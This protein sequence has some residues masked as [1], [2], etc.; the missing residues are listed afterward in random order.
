MYQLRSYQ[1]DAV[2]AIY[3][4]FG[5][6]TGN[7]VVAM[8]T[9]TGK[10]LVIAD[11]VK[12]AIERYPTTRIMMLTHVKELIEQN[13]EKL[14]SIWPTAPAGI[15]SAGLGRKEIRQITFAGIAS[16]ANKVDEIVR[17][18]GVDLI[19]VDE[20]HLI[21]PKQ[22]TMYRKLINKLKKKYPHLKVIG[23]TATA[24]RLGHG[25]I[26]EG[27]GALFTDFAIDMTTLEGFNWFFDQGYLTP[28]IPKPTMTEIDLSGIGKVGGEFN[29]GQLQDA[30]N[31]DEITYA[32]LQETM[33][34]AGD[35]KAWLIFATGID[36]VISICHAL[37]SM[38]ITCVPVHSKMS[39]KER[40][41]NIAAFKSGEA[42]ALVNMGVLTTGFDHPDV[43][44]IIMLRATNSPG[45]W[46]QML[47]RGTRNVY[48]DGYDL[49]TRQ[50]RRDA[51][52]NGPKPNCMVLDFAGNTPRLGPINDPVIPKKKGKGGG[53]APVRICETCSTY[54]HAS[55]RICPVCG[56][57]YPPEVKISSRAG[58][59]EL[60]ASNGKKKKSNEPQI[61]TFKVDKVIYTQHNK[62]GKPPAMLATYYCGLRKFTNYVCLEHEGYARKK[63]RDWWREAMSNGGKT[64]MSEVEVPEL[65]S[66]ALGM[67]ADIPVATHLRV[68]VNKTY[69]EIMAYDYTGTG[70][71]GAANLNLGELNV[72]QSILK[73]GA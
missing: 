24:Y 28:L 43:D 46:V 72:P 63:G 57:E 38:G 15:Y 16:I 3:N 45:L 20:C 32:A 53:D 54:I 47:G 39:T 52:E 1:Q 48:A 14:T 56:H 67:A 61:E 69:P 51:I 62:Q 34:V 36:H 37:D 42:Q 4:Y 66:V 71:A 12:G 9:G 68:W 17:A 21:S 18:G 29:Q 44:L 2:N 5:R 73:A 31:K 55:L 35:R 8:P 65:T 64:N 40:D 33:E 19:L 6:A 23:L 70:F 58:D 10:S 30:T 11:F 26:T 25:L 59:A 60:I 50:G 41:A 7:P 27:D 22:Q 13:F 49:S